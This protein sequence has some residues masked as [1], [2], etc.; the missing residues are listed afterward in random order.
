MKPVLEELMESWDYDDAVKAMIS[1]VQDYTTRTL[2]AARALYIAHEKLSNQGYRSDLT[3][4][5]MVRGYSDT[6][7]QMAGSSISTSRQL[8]ESKEGE[9]PHTFEQFCKDINIPDRTARRWLRCYDPDIDYIFE[10]EEV[11]QKA[12]DELDVFYED[13]RSKRT[14]EPGYIPPEINLKWNKTLKKWSEN[15]YQA[16]LYQKEYLK[17]NPTS[18]QARTSVS[19]KYQQYGLWSFDYIQDLTQKCIEETQ[20]SGAKDY[21]EKVEKYKDRIPKNVEPNTLMRI[22]VI[23]RATLSKL[24]A[25]DKKQVAILLSEII[26]EDYL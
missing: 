1:F 9:E 3:S 6:S 14:D 26:R 5:Q 25:E 7:G 21:Y 10:E 4:S 20:G 16:W 12:K 15:K 13:V 11:K 17:L 8:A 18:G 19:D 24:S 23:V 2:V 22:P